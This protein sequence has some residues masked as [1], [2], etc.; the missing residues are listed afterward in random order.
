MLSGVVT[1][2]H[3]G[4]TVAVILL[5]WLLRVSMPL[6]PSAAREA[7]NGWRAVF[8]AGLVL[9]VIVA[10]APISWPMALAAAMVGVG[11]LVGSGERRPDVLARPIAAAVLPA[12][13]LLP[14]S[15]RLLSSPALFLTEAGRVAPDTSSVADHAWLLPW[16][17]LDAAG[18][19]P[20]WLSLGLVL[21]ALAALLRTDRRGAIAA[22]WAAVS[23][24]LVT[25]A[26]MAAATITIPGTSDQAFVWVG[27]PVALASAGAIVAVGLAADG[28]SRFIEAGHFGWRQPLAAVTAIIAL[29]GP[30]A[31]LVWW[32]AVA[33]QGDL[34]RDQAVP[35][36][37]YM[38]AAMRTTDQRVLVVDATAAADSAGASSDTYTVYS[39]DGVRLGDDSVVPAPNPAFTGLVTNLLSEASES[40]VTRLAQLGIAYVVLPAPYDTDQ[41]A[42][43]D[44][45]AGLTASTST[46]RLLGWQVDVPGRDAATPAEHGGHRGWWVVLQVLLVLSAIVLAA[47]SIQRQRSAEPVE[48]AEPAET[49]ETAE[50]HMRHEA[51]AS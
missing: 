12:A 21:A 25:T 6:R 31:G 29:V 14:W 8:G 13:L 2:G 16:G 11:L 51:G 26:V 10:F 38:S 34:T 41:V 7:P 9:S 3:L 45:A 48:P 50:R 42:Q 4:T 27:L 22:A 46:R 20:W 44:G 23:L 43:L 5:P 32:V 15:A 35:V 19:A 37:A 30:V 39:G 33:P 28:V 36:P 24:G 17:R 47:P 18:A 1:S 40:D 49:R